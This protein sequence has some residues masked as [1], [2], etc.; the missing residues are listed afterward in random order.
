M[1]ILVYFFAAYA[2]IGISF[3][4]IEIWRDWR[5]NGSIMKQLDQAELSVETSQEIEKMRAELG[6]KSVCRL[7]KI[8]AGLVLAVLFVEAV[9]AWPLHLAHAIRGKKPL[10]A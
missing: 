6:Q 8:A 4:A 2:V 1:T 9:T 3:F 5:K 7:K 10:S